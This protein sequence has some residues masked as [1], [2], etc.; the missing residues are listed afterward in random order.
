MNRG[1]QIGISAAF[2]ALTFLS[3]A[4]YAG[5][6]AEQQLGEALYFDANLSLNANQSCASCHDPAAGFV[7]PRNTAPDGMF[8]DQVPTYFPV[9]MGSEDGEGTNGGPLF[10]GLNSPSSAYAVYS[11]FFHWDG[12]TGFYIGGQFWNGRANSLA[13]QAAGPFLN[14]VEMAMPDKWSVVDRVRTSGA[15][16]YAN[17]FMDVYGLDLASIPP[18]DW[19]VAPVPD[20]QLPAGVREAYDSIAKAIGEFEKSELFN[21]FDS[22]FDYYLAGM[23]QL[24]RSEEKGMQLFNT[25]AKCNLCHIS[26]PTLAPDGTTT[27]PPLFTDYTYDNLGLPQNLYIPGTPIDPGLGGRQDIAANDPLG[28]QLGKHKVMSLRN[29]ALTPPYGHNGVFQ[30]LEQIVHFYNTRDQLPFCDQA[31]GNTD[32]GFGTTCWPEP[33]VPRNVNTAELGLLRLTPQQ[34]ADIVAFLNTLTDGWG[35]ENGMAPLPR[36]VMPPTP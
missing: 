13:G 27:I 26:T 14:P 31:L 7:D 12:V 2:L 30:T 18:Y 9:S 34:E 25:K 20:A 32:P 8:P 3:G 15:A 6:S 21:K 17:M 5:L 11:P 23:T 22:K 36:P 29:I 1:T 35:P 16:D 10:G 4:A 28:L 19:T 24:T 33:E